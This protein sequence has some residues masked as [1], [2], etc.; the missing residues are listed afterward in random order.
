MTLSYRGAE[1]IAM[2]RDLM[3]RNHL[4]PFERTVLRLTDSGMS[5]AEI[6]WRFRR[7]PGHIERVID[8]SRL[9]RSE[10]EARTSDELRPV[11][12]CVLRARDEGVGTAEIAAR[13]RRTPGHVARVERYASFKLA[14][15]ATS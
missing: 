13:L 12:R 14:R 5:T 11:E 10:N 1:Q 3:E 9:P 15:A 2:G 4:R 7:S 8:L 6:A